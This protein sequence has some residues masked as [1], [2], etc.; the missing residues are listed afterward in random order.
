[1][2]KAGNNYLIMEGTE[3]EIGAEI[4]SILAAYRNHLYKLYSPAEAKS[5][6]DDVIR[7]GSVTEEEVKKEMKKVKDELKQ[8]LNELFEQ[9]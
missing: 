4:V 9:N 3:S 2:I 7:T 6:F 8:M 5:R 1:M